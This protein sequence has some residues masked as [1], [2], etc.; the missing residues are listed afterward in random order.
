M[1]KIS[2]ITI[3]LLCLCLLQC[4]LLVEKLKEIAESMEEQ[5]EEPKHSSSSQSSNEKHR[6]SVD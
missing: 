5:Q 4:A 6:K 2:I 3:A 1:K